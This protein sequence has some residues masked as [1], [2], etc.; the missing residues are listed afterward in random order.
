MLLL[1][2]SRTPLGRY[3]K[4]L[5]S[6]WHF[7]FYVASEKE[8]I[9]KGERCLQR[10]TKKLGRIKECSP[11]PIPHPFL[12]LEERNVESN[13]MFFFKKNLIVYGVF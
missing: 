13:F 9:S 4:K 2:L 6:L 8:E 7:C 10:Y 11:F 1:S 12:P 5:Y 3:Q